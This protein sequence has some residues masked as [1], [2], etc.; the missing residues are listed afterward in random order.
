[1]IPG[2]TDLFG[3]GLAYFALNLISSSVWQIS[4]GGVIITTAIFSKIFLHKKF[5]K[6]TVIGCL[7]TFVGITLV[8]L[9]EIL[10]TEEKMSL[11]GQNSVGEQIVGVILLFVSLIFT[12]ATLVS[13]KIIFNKYTI[14]PLKMVFIEGIFGLFGISIIILFASYFECPSWGSI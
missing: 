1:M 2:F 8:Q 9:F 12:T 10:F 4:R 6:S 5:D 11:E 14:N 13:E 3:S 7:F